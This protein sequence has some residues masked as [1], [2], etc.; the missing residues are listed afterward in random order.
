MAFSLF[1]AVLLDAAVVFCCIACLVAFAR[2]SVTHPATVYLLFHCGFVS[3][4]AIAIL[5]GATT[6]FA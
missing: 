1:N 2:L 3:F 6:L 5:A 4:R